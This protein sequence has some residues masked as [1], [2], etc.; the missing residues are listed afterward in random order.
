MKKMVKMFHILFHNGIHRTIFGSSH[1]LTKNT[2]RI[3]RSCEKKS[4]ITLPQIV[5]KPIGCRQLQQAVHLIVDGSYQFLPAA[6]C[7]ML[8]LFKQITEFHQ[9]TVFSQLTIHH[10]PCCFLIQLH[11]LQINTLYVIHILCHHRKLIGKPFLRK[12]VIVICF[13]SCLLNILQKC[14]EF[15]QFHGFIA[16]LTSPH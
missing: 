10:Q 3:F 8:R 16:P 1:R 7:V 5:V 15:N 4:N 2:E 14:F 11:R 9:N 13:L 6:S 12:Q